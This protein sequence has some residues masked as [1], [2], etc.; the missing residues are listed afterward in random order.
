MYFHNSFNILHIFEY[1]PLDDFFSLGDKLHGVR[2]DEY[3]GGGTLC[4]YHHEFYQKL[5]FKKC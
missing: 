3:G 2:F 4:L 5:L 1:H